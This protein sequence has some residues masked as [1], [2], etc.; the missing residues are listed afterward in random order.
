MKEI[1]NQNYLYEKNNTTTKAYFITKI[2][3]VR[4]M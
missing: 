2:I 1:H 3:Y 4:E